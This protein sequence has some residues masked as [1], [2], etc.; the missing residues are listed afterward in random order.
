M[1]GHSRTSVRISAPPSADTSRFMRWAERIW[2]SDMEP[3][4]ARRPRRTPQ[5]PSYRDS[6]E[7]NTG[8]AAISR[9]RHPCTAPLYEAHAIDSHMP[10]GGAPMTAIRRIC[11]YCGSGPGADP[12]FAEAARKLGTTLAENK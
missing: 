4:K 8:R 10:A 12:A 2:E 5:C 1:Y 3:G 7:Q 6:K 9:P 11:V